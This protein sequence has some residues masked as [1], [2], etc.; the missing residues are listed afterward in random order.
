M[1]K[2]VAF[3]RFIA[4]FP[5]SL[6]NKCREKFKD[7]PVPCC[8]SKIGVMTWNPPAAP[9][10]ILIHNTLGAQNLAATFSYFAAL[11]TCK[12]IRNIRITCAPSAK[13]FQLSDGKVARL[14]V[15]QLIGVT[16]TP[17]PVALDI[18]FSLGCLLKNCFLSL[19]SPR[20]RVFISCLTLSSEGGVPP[21]FRTKENSHLSATATARCLEPPSPLDLKVTSGLTHVSN[22]EKTTPKCTICESTC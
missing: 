8:F 15:T 19:M 4:C 1:G 16:P 17:C 18:L 2:E 3:K 14:T 10:P 11:Y 20:L 12:M 22:C 6:L 7:C 9:P 5:K 21:Y 13:T